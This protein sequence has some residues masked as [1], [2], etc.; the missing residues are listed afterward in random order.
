MDILMATIILN[1]YQSH[2]FNFSSVVFNNSLLQSTLE[3]FACGTQLFLGNQVLFSSQARLSILDLIV[4]FLFWPARLH[5][6][7]VLLNFFIPLQTVSPRICSFSWWRNYC[8]PSCGELQSYFYLS[9]FPE[10]NSLV[11]FISLH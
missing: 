11:K 7:P 10:L 8:D 5:I 2:L 3:S 9:S 1:K 6:F 4:C